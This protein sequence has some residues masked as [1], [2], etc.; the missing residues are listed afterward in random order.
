[1]AMRYNYFAIVLSAHVFFSTSWSEVTTPLEITIKPDPDALFWK[2]D[3]PR[4]EAFSSYNGPED[5]SDIEKYRQ[6]RNQAIEF[7][8]ANWTTLPR[9]D[10]AQYIF[11]IYEKLLK[12]H[13]KPND[14][15]YR[16]SPR[17]LTCKTYKESSFHPQMGNHKTNAVGLTQIVP[18]TLNDIFNNER[19]AFRSKLPRFSNIDNGPDFQKV[20]LWDPVA[21]MEAGLA[22]MESKRR[23]GGHSG[24]SVRPI[25]ESYLGSS[26]DNNKAYADSIFKCARCAENNNNTFPAKCLCQAT[27]GDSGCYNE[28]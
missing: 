24:D 1:M 16:F 11:G 8:N 19:L 9:P 13:Q 23:Y 18:D 28:K 20:M 4:K 26:P 2:Y 10:K 5:T 14:L 21:Q 12:M 7:E 3:P 17:I 6:V 22:V 25:L 27:P 15:S